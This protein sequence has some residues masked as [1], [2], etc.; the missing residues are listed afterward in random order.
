MVVQLSIPVAE[1]SSLIGLGFTR[2]EVWQSIDQGNSYQEA[3]AAS[4]AA[5]FIDSKDALTTFQMGG[6]LLKVIVNG[7]AEASILFSGLIQYWTPLQ[8]ANRI[9]EV[10]P[11]LASVVGV[12]VRLTS[13]TT[14]RVSS[15]LVTYCDAHDLYDAGAAAVGKAVRITLVSG[16]FLYTFSDVAGI[17]DHRYKWRFTANG[18][19]PIS[20]FSERV[21]P[22]PIPATGIA[23]SVGSARFLG[24]D[25]RPQKRSIILVTDAP[26]SPIS[27]FAVGDE[28]PMVIESDE[29][30][31]LQLVLVQ[32]SK[33]RVAIE[34]TAYVREFTVPATPSFD[35]L[36]VMAAAVDPF[37]IQ[38]SPPFLTRRSI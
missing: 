16:T 15:L 32:L 6:R 23:L 1:V 34:G 24:L 7:G 33:V 22:T 19:N 2:I 38:T 36:T 14:G 5:A 37:T 20:E 13:P 11:G 4:P 28:A 3:T 29:E 26:P 12:A 21:F 35:L 8:V 31:L 25:G 17:L 30:G 9:N 27:G 10:V 18:V